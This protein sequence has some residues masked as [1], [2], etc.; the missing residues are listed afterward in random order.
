[1]SLMSMCHRRLRVAYV[2][3]TGGNALD[4]VHQ[5]KLPE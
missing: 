5:P 2:E 3:F 4:D 1:M